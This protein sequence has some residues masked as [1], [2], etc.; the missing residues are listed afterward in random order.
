M[1]AA[2]VLCAS[3]V[4]VIFWNQA[5]NIFLAVWSLIIPFAVWTGLRAHRL[6]A[7]MAE[8]QTAS[9]RSIDRAIKTALCMGVWWGALPVA[10]FPDAG[11]AQ[12][13]FLT[14]LAAGMLCGTGFALATIPMASFAAVSPIAIGSIVALVLD[15]NELWLVASC[16]VIVYTVAILFS[17]LTHGQLLISRFLSQEKVEDQKDT[18]R[19]LLHEFEDNSS[20]WLWETDRDG[21][22]VNVPNR[23]AEVFC[24]PRKAL[25]D[26]KLMDLLPIYEQNHDHESRNSIA[27]LQSRLE[28]G[29]AFRHLTILTAINGE[30]KWLSFS[31]RP[32]HS[33]TGDFLGYRGVGSDVTTEKLVEARLE[34]LARNDSLTGVANRMY[35]RQLL[36]TELAEA[37]DLGHSLAVFSLDLDEFKLVNDLRGH[38]FGDALLRAVANRIVKHVNQQGI[39][40]RIGG[41]EFAILHRCSDQPSAAT[42]LANELIGAFSEPF[43][44]DG[45]SVKTGTSIGICIAPAHGKDVDS[46]MKNTDLA[47]FA[48]KKAGGNQ[49]RLYEPEMGQHLRLSRSLEVDLK[50]AIE[51]D[52]LCLHYQP[53]V[54]SSSGMICG[55]ESLMRWHHPEFGMISP[56]E[57]I[58]IAERIGEIP[59]LGT[60][61]ILQ[62]CQAAQHWPE[63]L[64]VAINLSPL[65]FHNGDICSIVADALTKTSIAPERL[66]LEITEGV[67]MRNTGDVL[68]QLRDLKRLGVTIALDDFGT[69]YSSLSYLWRFPFDKIK[70]DRS[71]VSALGSGVGVEEILR[72]IVLLA[73]SLNAKV[74]AEGVETREQ[75]RYL[76]DL[77][78][79][80]LQG[81]LYGMPKPDYESSLM[82]LDQFQRLHKHVPFDAVQHAA[83]SENHTAFATGR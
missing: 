66:E 57:F 30:R 73:Q 12:Q 67:M 62:A 63:N 47:L 5:S 11:A 9:R 20:D 49:L 36:A 74:V 35:F 33:R 77:G 14:C 46:V 22:M 43:E 37:N 64:S 6:S 18:I 82:L 44:I 38:P 32:L 69:G 21:C 80:Q 65:Q 1:M 78:C 71:F 15:H 83:E 10:L 56:T 76:T 23:M 79:D 45:A 68:D 52:Q 61:A 29:E 26:R 2:N 75:S 48:A 40:A 27:R 24:Q 25:L 54:D 55:F 3:M 8:K 39:V 13:V 51:N 7:V 17:A 70:I 58:S 34:H 31:G 42:A 41:D 50:Q 59:E 53:L 4:C 16:L 28:K 72:S 19:L 60:W 81:F